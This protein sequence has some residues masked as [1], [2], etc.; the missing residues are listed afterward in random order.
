MHISRTEWSPQCPKVFHE[1]CSDMLFKG[2]KADNENRFKFINDT[3]KALNSQTPSTNKEIDTKKLSYTDINSF[4]YCASKFFKYYEPSEK[5]AG[6]LLNQLNAYGNTLP[7]LNDKIVA[8]I[9]SNLLKAKAN[10]LIHEQIDNKESDKTETDFSTKA[11]NK[12]N[13]LSK[14]EK[15][16]ALKHEKKHK[17]FA[18]KS[19]HFFR[20][21]MTIASVG[22]AGTIAGS[23]IS[24]SVLGIVIGLPI[25]AG[26]LAL[27]GLSLIPRQRYVHYL[28]E[29]EKEQAALQGSIHRLETLDNCRRVI[30]DPKFKAFADQHQFDLA[31]NSS[32]EL[33][34]LCNNF[35][36]AK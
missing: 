33:V 26:G 29:S 16:S 25:L 31:K 35:M 7:G 6:E 23:I 18:S 11:L 30:Q 17:E 36:R 14:E 21:T 10:I 20:L 5:E 2:R 8:D 15:D 4:I 9:K 13:S 1:Q 22:I 27:M 34:N 32:E 12:I 24:L 3:F 28:K 19:K